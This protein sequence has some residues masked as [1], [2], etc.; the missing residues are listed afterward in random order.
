MAIC[1]ECGLPIP[2]CNALAAYRKAI[3]EHRRQCYIDVPELSS[4]V[5]MAEEE[6]N[7]YMETYKAK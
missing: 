2:I 5:E 3:E 6:Y 4:F 1:E 7:R